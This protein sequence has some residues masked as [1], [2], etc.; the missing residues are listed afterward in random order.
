MSDS[1][2]AED[3]F[4]RR[5]GLDRGRVESIVDASLHGADDGEMFMEYRQSESFVWDDSRLKSASFDTSQGFGIRAVVGESTGYAHAS[6]LSDSA[7]RRSAAAI[8]AVKSGHQGTYADNP[9]GTN[10]F[11][12]NDDNPLD[13]I[14]FADKVALLEKID[15]YAR[16]KDSRV[17]Q[18]SASLLASWQVVEIIRA[19]GHRVGDIRPMVR[20]NIQVV[21][22]EGDRQE[23]G[24]YGAGGR[25]A[26]QDYINPDA[27]QADVDEALRQ[28]VVNLDSVPAPAGEMQVVLGPGW[29][30]IL[31]HEAIGH[32]LEGD[33]NRKKTSAFSGL[34][35]QRIAAP[36]VTV[37]DDGTLSNRRGSLSVDD[38]GTPTQRTVLIEDG[39]LKGY[40][41]DR[42]NARL[43]GVAPTGN[44]RRQDYANSPM[45]RMTNTTMENGDR[46]PAEILA[47][48]KDGIYATAFGGGQVDI[49]SGKFVFSCTEAYLVKDGKLGAPVKGATLIGNGPDVLTKVSAIGN[50]T[51]LDPGIGTCG[52]HGQGVPVGVGQPTMLIDGLTVGGTSA[53]K[54]GGAS[55]MS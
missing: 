51:E 7:M 26:Y 42:M 1:A 4:F 40:M 48:V 12:Y 55:Q 27:W 33:F 21:V 36:G 49:T 23:S 31:L 16:E 35:G 3:L 5:A 38:E 41:Q 45:P 52:K 47:S 32:G 34:M 2:K 14:P 28:A 43:M 44:G 20:L 18:V 13:E 17:R 8:E 22:G 25:A 9:A 6:D 46:D 29:P 54:G 19:G 10:Q 37:V 50:D 30:G 11:Q 39:I 53:M 15:A 24:S